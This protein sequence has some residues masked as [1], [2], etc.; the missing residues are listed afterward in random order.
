MKAQDAQ[1]QSTGPRLTL[2]VMGVSG[3]GKSTVATAIASALNL[4]C[5]DGDDLHAP[6]S[7]QKMKSGQA[8]DDDDRWPWLDRVG[9]LLADGHAAPA[10]L[11]VSC[12]ALKRSYRDRIRQ[13]APSLRFVFLDG[14]SDLIQSRLQQRQGHYMPATLLASQLL[15]LQRPGLDE[16]DVLHL[17]I[18]DSVPELVNQVLSSL[19]V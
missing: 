8:L 13:A 6:A 9:S 1:A 10:G 15:T 3:T 7:V 18:A 17:N 19:G 14:S 16:P 4:P 2:V 12:S 5:L 11:V